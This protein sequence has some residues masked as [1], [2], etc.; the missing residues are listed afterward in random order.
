MLFGNG[1]ALKESLLLFDK[2]AT[3]EFLMTIADQLKLEEKRFDCANL[4]LEV[5][6]SVLA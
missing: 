6:A 5:R 1:L 2:I 3:Q 4:L